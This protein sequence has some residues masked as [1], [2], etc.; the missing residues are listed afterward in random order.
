MPVVEQAQHAGF[1]ARMT[2]LIST[3]TPWHRRLWRTSTLELAAELLDESVRPGVRKAAIEDQRK[4]LMHS[5]R[6][7]LGIKDR[8]SSVQTELGRFSPGITP[9]SH[10]WI[11][12]NV[13]VDT[14]RQSYLQNWAEVFEAPRNVVGPKD[15][16]GAVRRITAHILGSGMHK[17]SLFSWLAALESNPAVVTVSDFL[18]EAHRRLIRPERNYTFCV[19]VESGINFTH[20]TPVGW[21]DAAQT[22]AWIGTNVSS[23]PSVRQHGSFLLSVQALDVNTAAERA[24]T[25]LDTLAAKFKLGTSAP[26]VLS[27]TMWSKDKGSSYP[28]RATNRLVSVKSF[29][30]LGRLHDFEEPQYLSNVLVLAQP[31]QTGAPHIAIVSGW[32]AIESMLVGPSDENDSVGASRFALIVAVSMIRAELTRLALKYAESHE[33]TFADELSACAENIDRA[34]LIVMRLSEAPDSMMKDTVD[35]LAVDRIVPAVTNPRSEIEK[36][37]SILTREFT[38]LYRKRNMTVHGGHITGV[39]LHSVSELLTPLIGAGIDRV[40]HVGLKFD[41]TPIQMSATAEARL[42]YLVPATRE[43]PGN[44]L[45]ILEF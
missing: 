5:L 14:M 11:V 10:D 20:S 41:V 39:N 27:S 29:E 30:R 17:N 18:R 2:E 23:A 25:R 15:L 37:R 19:P 42:N 28:T 3:Q 7:D 16:D 45:D 1:V 26:I 36:I 40:V 12:V 8:G 6:T 38:R 13:H 43:N 33:D 4:Y 9:E 44:L 31:L 22:A 32:A 24:R 35:N 21:M 34:R